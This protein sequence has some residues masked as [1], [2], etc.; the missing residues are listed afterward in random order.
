ME[1]ILIFAYPLWYGLLALEVR[2]NYADNIY[3]HHNIKV[4]EI[5][6]WLQLVLVKCLPFTFY[7]IW[8]LFLHSH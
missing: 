6:N 1:L 5:S 2:Y 7:I 3:V 4:S 8:F